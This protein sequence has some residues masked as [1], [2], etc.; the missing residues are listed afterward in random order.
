MIHKCKKKERKKESLHSNVSRNNLRMELNLE[1]SVVNQI[2]TRA[3]LYN[4]LKYTKKILPDTS[5]N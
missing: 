2:M 3:H 1:A 5:I 4:P